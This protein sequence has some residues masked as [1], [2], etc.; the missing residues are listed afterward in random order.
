MFC[1]G[2]AFAEPAVGTVFDEATVEASAWRADAV[3][4]SVAAVAGQAGMVRE[5]FL[6]GFAGNDD[7][8]AGSGPGVSHGDDSPVA[9]PADD[10]HVD[11]APVVLALRCALLVVDIDQR[12]VDNP[13]LP[14]VSRWW[15]EEF[16][17]RFGEPRHDPVGGGVGDAEEGFE[18]LHGEVGAV[19]EHDEEGPV[20]ERQLPGPAP[21]RIGCEVPQLPDEV[22]HVGP[23]RPVQARRSPEAQWARRRRMRVIVGTEVLLQY[24]ALSVGSCSF[25]VG[26]GAGQ[27]ADR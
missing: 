2:A 1:H 20:G 16:G 4:A 11:V 18:L 14:P 10:L 17:K 3:A 15:S 19:R 21:A 6:E 24:G 8:V 26:C 22:L 27:T 23:V 12:S 25:G 13:Q 9:G 5:C 7:V